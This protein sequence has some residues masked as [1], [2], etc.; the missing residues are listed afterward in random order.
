MSPTHAG[1]ESIAIKITIS[2]KTVRIQIVIGPLAVHLYHLVVLSA[3][4]SASCLWKNY[5]YM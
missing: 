1:S 2:R 5:T 3:R 4:I